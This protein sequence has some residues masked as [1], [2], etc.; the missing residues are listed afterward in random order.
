MLF[1]GSFLRGVASLFQCFEGGVGW[2]V[3]VFDHKPATVLSIW[4]FSMGRLLL[5]CLV[6]DLTYASRQSPLEAPNIF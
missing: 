2:V 1:C 6:K 5:L 4:P 3:P